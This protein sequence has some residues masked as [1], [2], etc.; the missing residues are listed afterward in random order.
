MVKSPD[1]SRRQRVSGTLGGLAAILLW[2]A[3]IALAR[4]VSESLGPL[5][6]AAVVCLVAGAASLGR[7]ACRPQLFRQVMRLPGR[8]LLGCGTLFAVYMIALFLAVGLAEDRSQVLEVGLVNYLWP[9]LTILLSV[10]ILGKTAG[11][12]LV[13]GTL[14][15]LAGVVLVMTQRASVS[16]Q[17]LSANV[18]SNP[19]AYA[20]A[21]AAA[22]SWAL[23][24]N[25]TRRWAGA[26]RV[27]AVNAFLPATG[28]LLLVLSLSVEKHVAWNGR[29]VVE[30]ACLG[31]LTWAAYGFWD[32]AMRKGDVV[33]VSACAYATPLLSTLLTCLYLRVSPAGNLWIGCC[34]IVVGSLLSWVSVAD[35]PTPE[36][37]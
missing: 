26:E 33:L 32:L 8:Y 27:G 11:L 36:T 15:A 5:T 24:S 4:S 35:Q 19:A 3:T 30:A 31:V 12:L 2:S 14:L 23:Y 9:A 18:A 29:A 10:A 17:S 34:L 13:P 25:L 21:L 20:L 7:F 22:C 37:G 6:A 28:I 1:L 16:W